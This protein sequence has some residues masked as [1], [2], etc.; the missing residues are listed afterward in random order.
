[1]D[2][3]KYL[4]EDVKWHTVSA[5]FQILDAAP[6]DT[7]LSNVNLVPYTSKGWVAIRLTDGSYEI[8][9][10]TLEAGEGYLDGLRRELMEEVGAELL[11]FAPL[12]AWFCRSSASKPYKPHLPHPEFY[13]FVGCGEIKLVSAPT[14]PED[15][16]QIAAVEV[17][18]LEDVVAR[19][20]SSGRP[21][22]ADLYRL[23][24]RVQKHF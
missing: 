24:A 5:K 16:E 20:T 21:D 13:R 1:M 7:L 2:E 14:N 23:A 3:L 4:F 17:L 22:L 10:G 18:S 9:G 15:G 19:F 11:T 12:G 8:P 6:P